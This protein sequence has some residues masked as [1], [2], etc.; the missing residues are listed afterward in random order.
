[1]DVH[2]VSYMR[3]KQML[4]VLVLNNVSVVTPATVDELVGDT[5][6][7]RRIFLYRKKQSNLAAQRSVDRHPGFEHS[8]FIAD[9]WRTIAS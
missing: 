6:Y 5:S 8:I 3:R 9:H 7:L 1:M 2:C 4:S